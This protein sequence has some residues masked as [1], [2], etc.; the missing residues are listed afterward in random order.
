MENNANDKKTSS[1]NSRVFLANSI[2]LLLNAVFSAYVLNYKPKIG[3][4]HVWLCSVLEV[5][6]AVFTVWTVVLCIRVLIKKAGGKKYAIA[7]MMLTIIM[8][9]MWTLTSLPYCKDFIGGSKTVTTDSYLVVIDELQFLD[10]GNRVELMIPEDTAEKL[11]AKENY[12]Y[13]FENNL[14]KYYDKITVTYF[15]ESKVVISILA[16]GQNQNLVL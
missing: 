16:E 15:P 1:I 6:L 9:V 5:L 13:D 4:Y 2:L 10:E 11:R 14:L 12:E 7:V 3:E 8:G